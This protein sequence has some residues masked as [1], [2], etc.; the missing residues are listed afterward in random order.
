MARLSVL[1]FLL[2]LSIAACAVELTFYG[3]GYLPDAR[4]V[5]LAPNGEVWVGSSGLI[6]V[7]AA[8]GAFLR[9]EPA[10]GQVNSIIF[11]AKGTPIVGY[12]DGFFRVGSGE[13]A[14]NVSGFKQYSPWEV[15]LDAKGCIY[16]TDGGNGVVKKFDVTGMLPVQ[17][18]TYTAPAADAMV[19]PYSLA[20]D[21][22]GRVYVSDEQKKGLCLFANDGTFL[23][24]LLPDRQC[25]RVR[26]QPDG[27]YVVTD[28]S[29]LVIKPETGDILRTIQ[30]PNGQHN[31][32]GFAVAADGSLF[33]G[34]FGGG[35]VK[36]ITPDGKVALTLGA[37]YKATL[38]MP[39]AWAPGTVVKAP[40]R[41]EAIASTPLGTV[42]PVFSVTLQPAVLP[43]EA[44]SNYANLQSCAPD[45]AWEKARDV[46]FQAQQRILAVA[47][48]ADALTVTMPAD[49]SSNLYRLLVHAEHKAEGGQV[50]AQ[51]P[52]RVVQPDAVANMTLY[53]PHQRSVFQQGE[54]AEVNVILRGKT[55]FPAGG[56][57]FTL[58]PRQGDSLAFQP[59]LPAWKVV[60]LPA[61]PSH[62]FT[63]HLDVAGIHAGRYLLQVDYTAGAV[64][65]R[66]TWPLEVVTTVMPTRF[67]I[68]FPEWSAGYT[69]IWGPFTGTGMRAESATVAKEGI[70]LYDTTIGGRNADP[71]L[72]F[73][74]RETQQAAGL[75]A[76]AAAD[77]ALP[78][79]ER[80]AATNPLEIELQEALRNGLTVQR[81][82]WGSHF[83]DNWG[84][85]SPLGMAR[86]NRVVQM[87]TQWQR[88]WP[89]W[90]GHRY[91]TLSIDEGDNP[92]QVALKD[93]LLQQGVKVPTNAELDWLR[94]GPQRQFISDAP[95][96][97]TQEYAGIGADAA[98]NVYL[99]SRGGV[100]VKYDPTG[101][102]LRKTQIGGE[103]IDIAVD[104]DGSVFAAH[105]GRMVTVVAP[106]GTTKPFSTPDFNGYSPR[107]I[108][109][110]KAGTLLVA[111][112]ENGRVVRFTRDGKQLAVVADKRNLQRPAGIAVLSDGTIAVLDGGR[113]GT[114]LFTAD[115]T[116]LTFLAGFGSHSAGGKG[117]VAAAADDTL[118][119]T[120]GW[121][122]VQHFDRTGK[123]LGVIGRGTFAPGGT[124][125]PMSVALTPNGNVLISD[126]AMPFASELTPDGNPVRL[127]GMNTLIADVRLD[128]HRVTWTEPL[129]ATVWM[130]VPGQE[131]DPHATL[132]AFARQGNAPW[133]PLAAQTYAGGD[134][135]ITPPPLTGD[136]TVRV[137]WAPKGATAEDPLH[138]D[139][140][141]TVSKTLPDAE[142]QKAADLFNRELF[143][144]E[145]WSRVRMGTLVR[146]T[147]LSDRIH[148][149]T[150]CTAPTNYGTPD[151]LAEGVWVPWRRDAVVAEAENE[152]HDHGSFPLMGPWYVARALEGPNAKPAWCSLLQWYWSS[153]HYQRPLRDTVLLLGAG[154]S[155]I[156]TGTTVT[157]MS[158]KSLAVHRKIVDELRRLGEASMNLDLPGRGGVAVLHSFIQ[159][160]M[161]PYMEE[162]FYTAHAAWY[163]LLR[164]HVPAGVVSEESIAAGALAPYKAVLLPALQF[165]LPPETLA[166]LERFRKA[167]GEVWVDLETRIPIPGAHVLPTKYRAFWAQDA[168]YWM[169]GGYGVG[170]YDGNYE[171]WRMKQGS[172]QR[173]PAVKAAFARFAVLPVSTTDPNVFLESRKGGGALYVFAG[174]DHYPDKPLYQTWLAGDAPVPAT[175]DF[176]LTG[177]V[178]DA[179]AMKRET[180]ATLKVA[181]TDADPAR[182]WA[183]LPAALA[184][185]SATLTTTP[186]ELR[187]V[188]T[189]QDA[190]GKTI[191]AVVPLEVTVLDPAGKEAFHLWRATDAT[192]TCTVRVPVR[193]PAT[194][195]TWTVTARELL[196]GLTATPAKAAVGAQPAAVLTADVEP[197]LLFD[198]KPISSWL[199]GLTGNE[200]WIALDKAQGDLTNEADRL[201]A[202][203]AARN[204]KARVVNI[205]ALPDVPVHLSYTMTDAEKQTWAQVQAGEKVG[206]RVEDQQFKVNGP[207]RLVLRP[208]ILLGT[209]GQNAWLND[210]DRF[211]LTRRPYSPSYPGPGRALL[212]YVWAPFYDGCDAVTIM[213]PDTAGVREG[214]NA[215]LKL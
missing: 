89:S 97:V 112:E 14:L 122:G 184:H 164:A 147:N 29:I 183:V 27:I 144:K 63:F 59:G 4:A 171:F 114:M 34:D 215:L 158:E 50:D 18:T 94:N 78:A 33:C 204:I 99:A 208:L 111:D 128:R 140:P 160:A 80:F 82:I 6:S 165:A 203:L 93:R 8:N 61:T 26:T 2:A 202:A 62:T 199:R 71:P 1:A 118:W 133:T 115:G 56:L 98:G 9:H 36:K 40:L 207:Q 96:P 162:H 136:V 211:R 120:E 77:P 139:F 196:S 126:V 73:W 69:D 90:I 142:A 192:G 92:E 85:A 23:R 32:M 37:S 195:G 79:P 84:M 76:Q 52:V 81:D 3:P 143:Y 170:G 102:L 191:P 197:T 180:A 163:D 17:L 103:I 83:M 110:E 88:E 172:D 75:M 19:R 213:A 117:D 95:A 132:Q 68:L 177:V 70:L 51:V 190:A 55:D 47:Q 167:G 39:D 101:H 166:G 15:A 141:V 16:G 149:N 179:L 58:A 106:D 182:I 53:V 186:G 116:P 43:G 87:W 125:L 135:V 161:D 209:P 178:Y 41:V 148:P 134:F 22:A 104:K 65:F 105:M 20:L 198:A 28:G 181:F 66:D 155:G 130:P 12:N 48:A 7:F 127:Y 13:K 121:G 21:A 137:V 201:A 176:T 109:V 31:A 194:P 214:I 153:E 159:E 145:Q 185:V 131:G 151:S 42:P 193:W 156:G 168:Y 24:R 152:G 30:A 212:Q 38:Q 74:S 154:A 169:H 189:V 57:T 46:Q 188:V 175:V 35:V 129:I 86:D 64:H 210:I 54:S 205:A 150:Q 91:L 45:P 49:V 146:W 44:D 72:N 138:A 5:G 107:G 10:S 60:P 124:S 206:T 108:A 157:K 100:L 123:K 119:A 11:D 113:G 173:L 187:A 200:V 67:R 174:N 25:W